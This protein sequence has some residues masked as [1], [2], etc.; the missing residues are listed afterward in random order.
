MKKMIRY[1]LVI[2][3]IC[4]LLALFLPSRTTK[5][6]G[7]RSV[8]TIEVVELGGVKQS[9]LIRG[10]EVSN[11]VVLLLH[12]GP[13]YSQISF[14]RKYQEK[15]EENFIVVNWDQRGSGKSY[16]L[17]INKETMNREQFISDTIELIDYLCETYEKEQIYIV[18]HSWGSELGLYVVDQYPEKIAAFI[19][20]GQ[21]VNGTEGES[22]SYDFTLRSAYENKNKKAISDLQKI[23][24]PPYTDVVNDTITQRKWLSKFG[25]VERKVNTLRDI[26]FGS[27]FS[28]E[29]TGIDGLKLALG[30]K[31]T[32]DA[33]WGHNIDL[34]FIERVPE[35][36]VPIYFVAGRYDYNTPSELIEE[37][38]NHIKAPKKE[39]IW[40]EESAHFPQFEE[41]DKF[42]AL[43]IRIKEENKS[44]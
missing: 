1:T 35:V 6:K 12:G 41:V 2:F 7:D 17:D 20:A 24:R 29:Y 8:A 26:I 36:K 28:P 16:A 4:I 11:P 42:N 37:Y 44:N 40:F 27:I 39:L 25:G 32:A 10:T 43:M 33:M 31:F 14:A 23:G 34:N 5:I 15:L 38:Y 9:L 22:I 3:L 18:G 13:G 19:S 21:V 30:S